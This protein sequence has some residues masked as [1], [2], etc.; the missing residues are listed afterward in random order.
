MIVD[1]HFLKWFW[2]FLGLP[3]VFL[4]G[5]LALAI[6][7]DSSATWGRAILEGPPGGSGKP[8]ECLGRPGGGGLGGWLVV[9]VGPAAGGGVFWGACGWG[10]SG[11]PGGAGGG[12][13]GSQM[14]V[15]GSLDCILVSHGC[16]GVAWGCPGQLVEQM[17]AQEASSEVRVVNW[18]PGAR[19]VCLNG[20]VFARGESL[21][22]QQQ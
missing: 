3:Q 21:E 18:S 1:I 7:K 2:G 15:L 10:M 5:A 9:S 19:F 16:L 12:F 20:A 13:L 22:Q 8:G 11:E 17:R 6:R 14:G 4:W